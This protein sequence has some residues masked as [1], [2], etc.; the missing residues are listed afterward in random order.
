MHAPDF[1]YRSDP[2]SRALSAA[3]APLGTLYGATVEWKCAHSDPH[4]PHARV[5]CVGNL[6]VGGSGKTPV[7]IA[8]AQMFRAKG[9]RTVFLA[10][11]YGR[12]SPDAIRV[13]AAI[14]D[15]SVVGDEALL[16]ARIAPTFVAADRAEGARLA[17]LHGAD[18]IIMDDGHQNFTL[19]KDV[20]LV[21][22]DGESAF[23][24]GRIVPAGPLRE[25]V[26]QGLARADAVLVVGGGDPPLGGFGGP[27]LRAQLMCGRR[28]DGQAFVAFAGIGRPGK[29]FL[30]LE[31]QGAKLLEVHAFADHHGYTAA[32]IARLKRRAAVAGAGLITTE[33]DFV[34]LNPNERDGIDVLPVRAVFDNPDAVEK[35]FA[36]AAARS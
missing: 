11:G 16:L 23:G 15:A 20:S 34:R 5:I 18:L 21:V 32:E 29:F 1:W 9:A 24:N 8:L 28:L 26:R 19:A 33:K 12:R 3:L 7:A 17:E 2:A 22:V 6:T 30:S 25:N 27:V 14:H 35:L 36:A 13:D 31:T 10:R 4:R